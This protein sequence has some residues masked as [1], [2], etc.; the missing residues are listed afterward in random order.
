MV[1][2]RLRGRESLSL[3]VTDGAVL[4]SLRKELVHLLKGLRGIRARG[5]K[6]PLCLQC[7]RRLFVSKPSLQ[8]RKPKPWDK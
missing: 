4:G 5:R 6:P 8:M 2:L 3:K 7:I 1:I